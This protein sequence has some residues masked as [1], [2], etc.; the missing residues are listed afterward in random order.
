MAKKSP[1]LITL[2]EY[3]LGITKVV[4]D[5]VFSVFSEHSNIK[6]HKVRASELLHAKQSIPEMVTCAFS[7]NGYFVSVAWHDD[8]LQGYGDSFHTYDKYAVPDELTNLR[9][10]PTIVKLNALLKV[11][12]QDPAIKCDT[13][14]E[15]THRMRQ[16]R[17]ADTIID[18]DED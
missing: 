18:D 3:V 11:L 16:V 1:T 6:R 4:P 2:K 8:K 10:D 9:L 5:A 15:V 7:G 12:K 17:A 14:V 13:F